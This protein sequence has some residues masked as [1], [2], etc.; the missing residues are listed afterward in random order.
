MAESKMREMTEPEARGMVFMLGFAVQ[1]AMVTIA[2]WATRSK[3]PMLD[4]ILDFGVALGQAT[5]ATQTL[6]HSSE[7]D[8]HSFDYLA[9]YYIKRIE[10]IKQQAASESD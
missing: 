6:G 5:K 1:F 3:R 2:Q 7:T 8:G 9:E 10:E 4:E